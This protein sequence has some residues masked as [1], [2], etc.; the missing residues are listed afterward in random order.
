VSESGGSARRGG[1]TGEGP[2]D[3][4]PAGRPRAAW[5]LAALLVVGGGLL[6]LATEDVP[7]PLVR[8][9]RAPDFALPRLSS[10]AEVSLADYRGQVVLLNF[11]ATWCKPCEDEMPAMA[12]LH[13]AL[14]DADFELLAVSV[15]E[16]PEPVRRFRERLDLPFPILLD[17]EQGTARRYQTTGFPETF[18]VD[19]SGRVVERYVGPRE[20]DAAPYEARI[21]ELLGASAG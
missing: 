20:W 5:L 1:A 7:E 16:S 2:P 13:G 11:W 21:R 10:G 3:P 15:D 18:L 6:V 4:A 17:P 9:A 19:P 8:G 12:R 14:A